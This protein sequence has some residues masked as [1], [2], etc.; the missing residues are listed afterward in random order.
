MTADTRLEKLLEIG[1]RPEAA[2]AA[3]ALPGRTSKI[4]KT[5][6]AMGILAGVAGFASLFCEPPRQGYMF[7]DVSEPLAAT[8]IVAVLS[9]VLGLLLAVIGCIR[10]A[11][12]G[13]RV[14]GYGLCLAT[15]GLAIAANAI[16]W[17]LFVIH[18]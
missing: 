16:W 17:M 15:V 11:A 6:L 8:I 9:S 4:A 13:K 18:V 2:A 10:I 5:S 7:P 1:T 14:T 12:S 3:A